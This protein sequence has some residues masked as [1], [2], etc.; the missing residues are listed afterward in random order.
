M[1]N[2]I[3]TPDGTVL[4]SKHRNDFQSHSDK[5]GEFYFTDGGT[6]YFRRSV[7]KIPYIDLNM[8]KERIQINGVWYVKETTNEEPIELNV[9][10]FIGC[11][12]E[13]SDYVWEAT[14]IYKS[15]DSNILYD[16]A[17][18]KFTDKTV[19]PWKEQHWDNDK[20]F[21]GIYNNNPES[22][23]DAEESMNTEGIRHFRAFIGELIKREWLTNED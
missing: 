8:E 22:M 11:S 17:D 4:E 1:R 20:W 23:P 2:I 18:I 10:D 21:F 7:N 14:R 3:M 12:Y 6:D 16:G 9:I 19:T 13:T 5:N 15:L